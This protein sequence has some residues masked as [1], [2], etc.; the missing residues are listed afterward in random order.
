MIGYVKVYK[1]EL[2]MKDYQVY[3]AYYCGICKSLGKRYGLIYRNLLNYDAVFLSIALDSINDYVCQL[4]D[5]RCILHPVK[6]KVRCTDSISIDYVADITVFMTYKKLLDDVADDNSLIAKIGAGAFNSAF[7]KAS[8]ELGELG[9]LIEENLLKLNK[10]ET[11]KSDSID[12]T[13]DCYGKIYSNIFTYKLDKELDILPAI[14]WLG[15]NIGRWIYIVDAYEDIESDIKKE[16]YNSILERYMFDSKD[17][18]EIYKNSIRDKISF[19]LYAALN[20]A[21]KS[22]DLI[23]KNVNSGIIKN[24][25]YEGLYSVTEKVL[26][27]DCKNGTEKSI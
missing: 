7:N 26:N 18:I 23:D 14:D 25:L 13:A 3:N 27:G 4:E 20:E 5:F 1:P 15:Y 17:S 16:R 9:P 10:L 24:I 22:Y 2:K 19:V 21:S 8:D 11:K 12:E 6:K